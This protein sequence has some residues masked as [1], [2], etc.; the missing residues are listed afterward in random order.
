M[1]S[2]FDKW[3]EEKAI[4]D[5]LKNLFIKWLKEVFGSDHKYFSE[6]EL[7]IHYDIFLEEWAEK[8]KQDMLQ[9]LK[10]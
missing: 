9:F 7:D 6:F 1:R 10:R 5:K 4:G 3:V 2:E 8:N